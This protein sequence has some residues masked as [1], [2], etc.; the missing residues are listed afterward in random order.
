MAIQDF[1]DPLIIQWNTDEAGN[2]ISVQVTNEEH[3]IVKN[4]ILL[5]Q[6]PDLF[7]KVQINSLYEIKNN[8]QITAINQFKVD[9][10]TGQVIFHSD[11]ESQTITI[12]QYHGR[13]IIYYSSDRIWVELDN[14]GNVKET[15]ADIFDKSKVVYKT[16]VATY[17]NI[18][19]TY[20][21][22]VIGWAVQ[23]EDNGRFYRWD[24]T[25]WVYFQILHPTQLA[26]L[27]TDM[28]D[29]VNLTTTIKT[30]IV[31]AINEIVGKI[32]SL[33]S[34]LTTVKTNIVNSI[35]ELFNKISD[36]QNEFFN[37]MKYVSIEK[38]GNNLKTALENETFVSIPKGT[39]ESE[40]LTRLL[41]WGKK[42]KGVGRQSVL[43]FTGNVI[44]FDMDAIRE[45][46]I[47]DI[48]VIVDATNTQDVFKITG[49][50]TNEAIN[51]NIKNV[52]ID[53][54]NSTQGQYTGIRL[55][56][57]PT[58]VYRN[59]IINP[60][61]ENCKNGILLEATDNGA[62]TSHNSIVNP[63]ILKFTNIAL[64]L[65]ENPM[66]TVI[67]N[68]VSS[69]R[70][71]DWTS[72][73]IERTGVKIS[74][75]SNSITDI[76][77]FNDGASG[78]FNAFDFTDIGIRSYNNSITGAA[79]GL[80]KG[81]ENI[82]NHI[83]DVN[84]VKRKNS[85]DTNLSSDPIRLSKTLASNLINNYNFMNGISPWLNQNTTSIISNSENKEYHS[86][87]VVITKSADG[88][89]IFYLDFPSK[90]LFTGKYLTFTASIKSAHKVFVFIDEG[91]PGF[92]RGSYHTGSGNTEILSVS[93]K[94][95]GGDVND[96][97]RVAIGFDNSVAV[98]SMIEVEWTNANYGRISPSTPMPSQPNYVH[99]N[100]GIA[101]IPSGST[102]IGVQH[103]L[104]ATPKIEDISVTPNNNLGNATK[105]WVDLASAN[106]F[107]IYVNVDPTT[108]A[109]FLWKAE[110]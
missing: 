72:E 50:I 89:A 9:Y 37:N 70:I 55:L 54:V 33:P 66:T 10:T 39:F 2:K 49:S 52:W 104:G 27:L 98:G 69:P 11:K 6:I 7:H 77:I 13:G 81:E 79:E 63:Y 30:S 64:G 38:Y 5:N 46:D 28:G 20:P 68:T 95:V 96:V 3:K 40:P 65:L 108:D 62:W 16:P 12:T 87:H 93:K 110:L 59:T 58:G 47:E 34:L 21:S 67:N 8:Q 51:N 45:C 43:K 94:I 26:T 88:S 32:G 73:N 1:N 48:K 4:K 24:G 56:S 19:T 31:N 86:K 41:L 22:P 91:V 80:I 106:V 23:V 76:Q 36:L 74:G 107:Y 99:K 83:F 75:M 25:T 61:I 78:T 18:T 60:S 17:A 109:T 53:T 71:L 92:L 57:T 85:S 101:T 100:K 44:P 35:N 97:V 82:I 29:K 90:D 103:G 105:Y 42:I 15:L 102:W 84:M 14:A